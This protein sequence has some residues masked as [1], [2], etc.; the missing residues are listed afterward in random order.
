M[1]H[2]RR[3][4]TSSTTLKHTRV[5]LSGRTIGQHVSRTAYGTTLGALDGRRYETKQSV[6]IR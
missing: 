1:G 3:P 4:C 6:P 2:G 5:K